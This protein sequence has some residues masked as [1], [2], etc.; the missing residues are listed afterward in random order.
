MSGGEFVIKKSAVNKIGVG[1]L[2]AI[3]GYANGGKAGPGMGAMGMLALGS[4]A[5]SG[6]I[7]A[8]MADGPDNLF[9][10]KTMVKAEMSWVI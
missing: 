2:N 9:V 10:C 6:I 4:G 5:A 1:T 7:G 8:A 3:N